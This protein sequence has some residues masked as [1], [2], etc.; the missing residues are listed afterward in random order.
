[1]SRSPP[2]LLRLDLSTMGKPI[3]EASR[4]T[5]VGMKVFSVPNIKR[6]GCAKSVMAALRKVDSAAE[7]QVDLDRRAVAVKSATGAQRL[8]CGRGAA[9]FEGEKLAT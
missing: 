2:G 9:G 3:S 6:S 7:V 1:M 8:V 5:E 4:D